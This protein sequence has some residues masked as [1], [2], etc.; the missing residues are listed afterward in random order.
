MHVHKKRGYR[1]L[2]VRAHVGEDAR[3]NLF[4]ADEGKRERERSG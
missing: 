4:S 1:G 2:S 3:V